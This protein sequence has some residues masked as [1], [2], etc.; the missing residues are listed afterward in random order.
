VTSTAPTHQEQGYDDQPEPDEDH[1][2]PEH[3]H[4]VGP[5]GEND[6]G[7]PAVH[8]LGTARITTRVG[9]VT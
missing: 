8:H 5:P 6:L 2:G 4:H 1:V 3:G 9:T 7:P